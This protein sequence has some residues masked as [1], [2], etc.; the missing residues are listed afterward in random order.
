M[1]N[2]AA[3]VWRA[4]RAD[5]MAM[6]GVVILVGVILVSAFAPFIATHDPNAINER[7]EGVV[8][9]FDGSSWQDAER[10]AD[11][12]MNAAHL[13]TEDPLQGVTVGE[14]GRVAERV[15]DGW[16]DLTPITDAT[17]LGVDGVGAG[18]TV[19]AVGEGGTALVRRDGVWELSTTPTEGTLHD[20][21]VLAADHAVAVGAGG[22]LLR[23]DGSD[24]EAIDHPG[25]EDL[26]GVRE[27]DTERV[28]VVGDRGTIFE[29]GPDGAQVVE[30]V[31]FRA[32]FGADVSADGT[33]LAV[34]ERGTILRNA[35]SLTEPGDWEEMRS[36]ENR[37]FEDVRYLDGGGALALGERGIA[38]RL[39]PA[40][41]AWEL[42]QTG[43]DRGLRGIGA[44]GATLVAVGTDPFVDELAPP[45][46]AHLFG[47]THLGRD[48]FSQTVWGARTALLVGLLAALMVTVIGTNV[49]LIAGYFKGRVGNL[50]MR[51]VDVMYAIPFEGFALVLVM[52]W[53]PSLSIVILAIGLLTWRTTARLIRSQVLTIA[54]RP[55]V[56]AARVAGASDWR[57]L[58]V[59]I[60]PNVMPLVFL[61]LAVAM[62]FAIT[63]EA[64]L[65]FLGIGPPRVFS[66]GGVLQEARQSGA[67]RTAWWWIIPPGLFIMV[68]VVAVF[69]ISRAL[70][71]LSNPRLARR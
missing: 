1:R 65:S 24:W 57:I 70:E 67:W 9:T 27:L 25:E 12:P 16:E 31:G 19:V 26:Y 29:V 6:I 17:L 23:W 49:G 56:K 45:S 36:P 38:V 10:V 30:G 43:Y 11:L 13:A 66:W 53:R 7:V 35:G 20:V 63:A 2:L 54:E 5:R 47:T 69:F 21:A 71:V 64:T 34:G 37:R 40:A 4:I 52:I 48:I 46:G 51:F 55:Y 60:A 39:D 61:Q 18:D 50:M 44:A 3:S 22:L 15:E 41:D 33:I 32:L 28:V 14:A 68:T 58:Y 42:E 8:V 59:H 62:A